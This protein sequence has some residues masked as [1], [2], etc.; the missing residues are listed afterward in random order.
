MVN[1]LIFKKKTIEKIEKITL[2][3]IEGIEV[4]E[5]KFINS[6]LLESICEDL[7]VEYDALEE[8]FD[9]F[10]KDV[11]DNYKFIPTEEAIDYDRRTW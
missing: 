1:L 10:K 4:G 2:S 8:E 11:A 7:I 3:K 5:Y 9:D 6:E